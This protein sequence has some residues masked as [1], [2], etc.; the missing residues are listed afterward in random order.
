MI[1]SRATFPDARGSRSGAVCSPRA[2]RRGDFCVTTL[3]ESW[4]RVVTYRQVM[5]PRFQ[6]WHEVTGTAAA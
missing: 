5:A 2:R 1:R 6:S 4:G 3:P